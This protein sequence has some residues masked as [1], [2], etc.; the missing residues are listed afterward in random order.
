M[1]EIKLLIERNM[2]KL[3]ND[4]TE[5]IVFKSEHNTNSFAGANIQIGGKSV[6]VGSKKRNLGVTFNLT[7]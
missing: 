1:S 6:E 2:L 7:L 4:K 3:N 5:C